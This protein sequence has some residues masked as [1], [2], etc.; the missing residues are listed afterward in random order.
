MPSAKGSSARRP[1][2]PKKKAPPRAS[3]VGP[4]VDAHDE[5]SP[6]E[7]EE[8]GEAEE[9]AHERSASV[10]DLVAALAPDE[11]SSQGGRK[12][13]RRGAASRSETPEPSELQGEAEGA[14]EGEAES[15]AE[16]GAESETVAA[17]PV[18]RTKRADGVQ[19]ADSIPIDPDDD[20]SNVEG[21]ASPRLMSIVESILFA[22][23]KPMSVRDLRR[24]LDAPSVRQI[25]LALK[26]LMTDTQDRGVV[27]SQVAGGFRLRTN[28]GNARWVQRMISGRPV[29][30]SRSQLEALAVIAYRQPI[31]KAEVDHVRGVDCG[32]VLKVLLERDLIKYVGRKDEAGRPHLYGTTVRFLEFFNLRSLR[33][34]PSLQEF[35][36]LTEESEATLRETLGH[37][38][39][40][41]GDQD[42][43]GQ[44]P[45]D[46]ATSEPP[47]TEDGKQ[48]DPLGAPAQD[49]APREGVVSDEFPHELD[50]S[51]QGMDP[52]EDPWRGATWTRGEASGSTEDEE[53]P[54]FLLFDPELEPESA[55]DEGRLIRGDEAEF[56]EDEEPGASEPTETFS[57][58]DTEG[59]FGIGEGPGSFTIGEG[60]FAVDAASETFDIEEGPGVSFTIAG[61]PERFGEGQE[62][63]TGPDA[64]E[65][66]DEDAPP[67]PEEGGE[68]S[69]ADDDPPEGT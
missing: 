19:L 14:S 36:E 21:E 18:G 46:F 56:A 34:M 32:A 33:D 40:D 23:N 31:T 17:E 59:S 41:G 13:G 52:E 48:D 65:A 51:E 50:R 67:A 69:S 1:K 24:L 45:L 27:L 38:D 60:A 43:F 7:A 11:A 54:G 63:R 64:V 30:L 16:S 47:A 29:R 28:P 62:D 26:A 61:A 42:P 57:I 15:E 37:E 5:V 2:A 10:G 39:P 35:E 55:A 66:A 44:E 53:D 68:A 22:S 58:D 6:S 25:Q 4:E 12:K 8:V 9:S 3:E 20:L 49:S